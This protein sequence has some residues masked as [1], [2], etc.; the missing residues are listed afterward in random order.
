MTGH[1]KKLIDPP[2]APNSNIHLH[3]YEG[4]YRNSY[5]RWGLMELQLCDY[6]LVRPSGLKTWIPTDL[7]L[8]FMCFLADSKIFHFG[9][10]EVVSKLGS[11]FFPL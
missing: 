11:P 9:S 3:N 6:K 7:G 2:L 5:L 8:K 4:G 1:I 10:Q